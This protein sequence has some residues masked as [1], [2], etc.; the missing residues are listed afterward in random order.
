MGEGVAMTGAG[1]EVGLAGAGCVDPGDA[2]DGAGVVPGP[3]MGDGVAT[4]T[5]FGGWPEPS[6]GSSGSSV[7]AVATAA[8]A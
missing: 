2:G 5:G 8:L 3:G 4:I 6:G 7:D 1:E